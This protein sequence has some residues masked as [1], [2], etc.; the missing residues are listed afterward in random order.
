MYQKNQEL[1]EMYNDLL[2]TEGLYHMN[3]VA[4]ELKTGRNT[5][6]SYLRGKGIMFY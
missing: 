6:L 1:E 3:T 5:M 4:K 2:N